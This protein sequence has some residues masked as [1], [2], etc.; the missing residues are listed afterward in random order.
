MSSAKNSSPSLS[1][2]ATSP[3]T[4]GFLQHIIGHEEL[5]SQL[6]SLI[7]RDKVPHAILFSGPTAVGKRTTARAFASTLLAGHLPLSEAK[8]QELEAHS[9][10]RFFSYHPDLHLIDLGIDRKDISVDDIRELIRHLQLKPYYGKAKV[11]IIHDAHRMSLQASN[12][13]LTTL[14]APTEN[15][16]LILISDSPHRLPPTILSRC[17][18]IYFSTLPAVQIKSLIIHVLGE[19][20]LTPA[21][22]DQLLALSPD[23]LNGLNLKQFV[24]SRHLTILDRTALRA[25]LV[26]VIKSSS[27]ILQ[28]LTAF[29]DQCP[30]PSDMALPYLSSLVSELSGNEKA[31]IPWHTLRQFFRCKLIG[32]T[33]QDNNH[34]TS[35]THLW[36]TR[37]LLTLEAEQL[38]NERNAN[39]QLQFSSLFIRS[40]QFPDDLPVDF[41]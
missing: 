23:S 41:F 40:S 4:L 38:I 21:E 3:N 1:P 8:K 11:A 19:D 10:F 5:V 35:Q 2:N 39:S 24:D 28:Q 18:G 31:A 33:A 20:L 36:A 15:T 27:R 14:E 29:F 17:Q 9:N 22:R 37:L 6:A 26:E 16:Y 32:D 30:S 12:A 25:H 7:S 13:L 34:T